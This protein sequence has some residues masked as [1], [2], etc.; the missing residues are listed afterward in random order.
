MLNGFLIL[1]H[2]DTRQ[3]GRLVRA[4]NEI[5]DT[6]PIACHHDISQAPLEPADFPENVTFVL[7][8]LKTGWGKFSVVEASLAALRQLYD[9]ADPDWFTLLSAADYPTA[10]AAP[11]RSEL[12]AS[13]ADVLIDFREPGMGEQEAADRFGARNPMLGHFEAPGN[14]LMTPR[15]YLAAQLWLPMLRQSASGVRLG[16]HTIGL[17]FP[18]PFHPFTQE[19]RCYYGDHWFTGSRR[20]ATALLN[21]TPRE[22]RLQTYL[23]RRACADECYYQTVLCNRPE[24]T[25]QR[26]TRRF[27]IWNGGGSHPKTLE[28]RDLDAIL[29]SGA[30]FARKF[31]AS[32]PM[33]DS[34]DEVLRAQA[35]VPA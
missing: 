31:A 23:R 21:P 24:L 6:P 5:Y 12:S 1:S 8:S 25:V 29:A 18:T 20:A 34:L 14:R 17:P 32:D 11:V 22:R 27:A 30:H 7:P 26:D 13:G 16:R 19:F 15:R 3:L 2:Q 33:L 10:L 4:L 28:S 35:G 9:K